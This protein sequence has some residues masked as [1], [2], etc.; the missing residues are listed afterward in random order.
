MSSF[1][2]EMY[3]FFEK[4]RIIFL[5]FLTI[6]SALLLF[7]ASRI[8]MEEDISGTMKGTGDQQ[9][10]EFV[11]RNFKFND[12]LILN[13]SHSDSS[14]QARPDS[15]IAFATL[16]VDTLNHQ[17]D[18]TYIQ[19]ITFQSSDSAMI[20]MM[21]MLNDHIPLFLDSKDYQ[22]IDSL[23]QPASI[24]LA[25]ESNYRILLSP[26]SMVMKTK[27][28]KDPL[29]ISNLVINKLKSLQ[30]GENYRLY[31]GCIFSDDMKHLFVFISSANP[32]NETSKNTVLVETLDH[33]IESIS[34]KIS[35]TITAEYFGGVAMAVSNATQLK[36]DIIL[37]L[38]IALALILILIGWYFRS[39]RIA[40]L[41][42]SPALFGGAFALAVLY[43]VK[44][45]ISAI[46]LGIGSV[47]LGLIVDYALYL[48]TNI[49]KKGSIELALNEMSLTIFMCCLTSAG[50]FLCLIFLNSSV[51]HDLG[52]FAAL[53]LIGA[54]TFTLVI[55]PHFL[56]SNTISSPAIKRLTWVDRI[57]G[58]ASENK[59]WLILM[60]L[61]ITV[62]S[63]FFFKK[64][65]FE[66]E[67]SSLN[68]V[69]PKLSKA[70]T[71]LDRISSIKLKN[72]YLVSTGQS[73]DKAL[74][75]Q[76][77]LLSGLNPIVQTGI[78]SK[79][80]SAAPLLI[81]DSL[82]QLRIQK[83]NSFWNAEKISLLNQSL[84][85]SGKACGFREDA[86]HP[87]I[88]TLSKEY[89]PIRYN[90]DFLAK[91]P[92]IADWINVKPGMAMVTSILAVQ[93]QNK[94]KVYESLTPYHHHV[95]FDR[96]SL[97][98]RF[99]ENV[100]LDFDL[101]VK[102]SMLF[103]TLLLVFSFGRIELGLNTA[104]P[105]FIS[106]MITLGFMGITGIKFN[107]F[108]II[109]SSFI[110]GLGVD[111]SILMMRGMQQS[112]KYGT[113]DISAYKVSILLSSATTLLG[114]GAL[115]FARHPALHSIAL[116]SIVGIISVVVI[117][118]AL[119]PFLNHW[120]IQ[121]RLENHQFP[122]TA[123]IFI[124]T[125][126]TWGNIVLVAVLMVIIGG[127]INL[128]LPIKRKKKE[129]LF[130]LIFSYLCKAYI[131]VTFPITRKIIN[132]N[133]EDFSKPA[134]II[135]NHQSLI[136]TPAFLRLHPKIIILTTSW[137]YKSPLFGPIARLASFYNVDNGIDSILD[138]L[139]EK[140][141]DGYSILIFPEA[142]RSRD[143]KINR[144]HRGAFYLAE[145]LQI[146]ILP[147][148]V[149]GSGDFLAKG[150]FWGKPNVLYMRILK[151]IEWTDTSLGLN[152]SER[153]RAF[154]Q[155][156]IREYKRFKAEEGTATYYR[157]N[158]RL[159]Y[160]FKGPVLEW[161]LR[162]KL[163]LENN[164]EFYCQTL[165][166]Q[167]RITDL[168]CGYGFITCML[169][170][171]SEDRIITGVDYDKEKIE[172]ARNGFLKNDQISFHCADISTFP[173]TPQDGFL[174]S[175]V[176]HYLLPE[177][178]ETLLRNCLENLKPGGIILI[179]DA[180]AELRK[181][182]KRSALTEFF[183]TRI[184]F[185][186][187]EDKSMR[188]HFTSAS[189]IGTVAA[190]YRATMEILDVKKVTSNNFFIIRKPASDKGMTPYSHDE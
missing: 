22:K 5:I 24:R 185:N 111:Y 179:R 128:L 27:I 33:A 89:K 124:K 29:G 88:E 175:D 170:L 154:R 134:I 186:K 173:L 45:T 149:F 125:F 102:L 42:L 146:D 57:A 144:F 90:S 72:I 133:R 75:N 95:A 107:I 163:S 74:Q 153:T 28:M 104:L 6:T 114:V 120:M 86:F 53:S 76:E 168:G 23:I 118:F 3:R 52:W 142:H 172:V 13:I 65:G 35:P 66:K 112:Y 189:K 190:E 81:S 152:Y 157:R 56:H 92:M 55:L 39:L 99:I 87:F 167:G 166:R 183:S 8:I 150:E 67:M 113:K 160:L 49:R 138:Q 11:I 148:L 41:S 48:I 79:V 97:T 147:M 78:I 12:K 132:P 73:L 115:F 162:V 26:A 14:V 19:S 47:L 181:R 62:F 2:I 54:A 80:S 126:I 4:N 164:Y 130:H 161:Y 143:Q 136:E 187:T 20:S 93:P 139:K 40:L 85:E 60:L 137:V 68:Y 188:L 145:K 127:F 59:T 159:N 16:L 61:L 177:K 156:Y 9:Q 158:L 108:N 51:L 182:Q 165:P 10:S 70:E 7:L 32:V 77:K 106:W 69:T 135:S 46:A 169:A 1:L 37:T 116:I 17:L 155:F 129:Y 178:Q 50:A 96:Q 101:L 174:L 123:K 109:I 122:V 176:L 15:L 131:F 58:P 43:L 82:Q 121:K 84:T 141:N 119:I 25:M 110:F 18:S 64:A 94:A 44:G 30:I 71:N 34:L 180:N 91:S 171:T 36:K 151:R 117:T 21:N 83:W 98:D 100:R 38:S 140:V 184:G 31:N 105:M 63:L 103:V